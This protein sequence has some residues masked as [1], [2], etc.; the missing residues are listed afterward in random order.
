MTLRCNSYDRLAGVRRNDTRAFE[1]RWVCGGS[2]RLM[3]MV[4]VE[5]KHQIPCGR[6]NVL[7]LSG[8]RWNVTRIWAAVK[9]HIRAVVH[10]DS[11]TI[12]VG[13]RHIR[14]VVD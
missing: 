7:N 3:T 11:L 1:L 9:A 4:V 8:N 14:D 2:N 5:R 12:D 13:D 10:D 6:L